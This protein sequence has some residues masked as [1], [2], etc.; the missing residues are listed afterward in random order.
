MFQAIFTSYTD[1]YQSDLNPVHKPL[2]AGVD[3]Y[4]ENGHWVFTEKFLRERGY[5]CGSGC[6]HCPYKSEGREQ[7]AKPQNLKC[8]MAKG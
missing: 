2:V 4:I 7:A 6:R 1:V 5:C 3:Y 8:K